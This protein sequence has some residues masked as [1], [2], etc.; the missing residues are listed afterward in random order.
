MVKVGDK[1]DGRKC[2]TKQAAVYTRT[3]SVAAFVAP[4]RPHSERV[5]DQHAWICSEC[6][7]EER[8]T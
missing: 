7:D 2:G 1:K 4:G 6:G 3:S 5:P 8:V